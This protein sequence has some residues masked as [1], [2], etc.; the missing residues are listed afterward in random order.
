M[1]L[2]TSAHD[3]ASNAVKVKVAQSAERALK[4]L[5]A[6]PSSSTASVLCSWSKENLDPYE[7]SASIKVSSMERKIQRR[8][9]K[10]ALHPPAPTNFDDLAILPEAFT[11][12]ATGQRFLLDNVELD[13]GTRMIV[14]ASADAIQWL[15]RAKVWSCDGTFAT[16]PLP[17]TQIYTIMAELNGTAF[18]AVF[19]LLPDK[20]GSTYRSLFSVLKVKLSEPLEVDTLLVDFEN[21][22]MNQFI[23]VFP[24]CKRISGCL[25][26]FK[27]ALWRK[28]G[29]KSLQRQYCSSLD[30][31]IAVN[32][33][34]A[35]I[36]VPAEE[37]PAYYEAILKELMPGICDRIDQTFDES[38]S[39]DIKANLN[40]W[41]TYFER[42]F[43]GSKSRFGYSNPRYSPKVWTKHDDILNDEKLTTNANELYHSQ[44][45][46]SIPLN[47]TLWKVLDV[48]R[49]QE[50]KARIRRQE[51]LGTPSSERKSLEN[52]HELKAVVSNR[53]E[54]SKIDYLKHVA[55]LSVIH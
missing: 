5:E 6:N 27:R 22:V 31:Q 36:Y 3:H 26:H 9:E 49:E 11:T 54:F 4:I 14:F 10:L 55:G 17:F 28:I 2:S 33:V 46:K 15:S 37:V 23:S 52:V 47:A 40:D 29:Q 24:R 25:V 8:K 19:A 39:D 30:I 50:V 16:A 20:L 44:L 43:I 48:F 41:F 38:E 53:L 32:C 18:P 45:R 42:T 34:S 7:K 13:G 12:T 35:L 51:Q 1:I 21:S